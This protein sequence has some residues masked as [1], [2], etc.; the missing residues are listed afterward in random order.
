MRVAKFLLGLF[1]IACSIGTS[2][3]YFVPHSTSRMKQIFEDGHYEYLL[4]DIPPGV[5]FLACF[6]LGA[7]LAGTAFRSADKRQARSEPTPNP[8]IQRTAPRSDA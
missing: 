3:F 6:V 4:W 1:L 7:W 5:C 2:L 8:A